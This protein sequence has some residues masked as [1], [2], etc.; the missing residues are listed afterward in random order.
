MNK[1][2]ICGEPAA[3]MA[4]GARRHD[5]KKLSRCPLALTSHCTRLPE[6]RSGTSSDCVHSCEHE[7]V[8]ERVERPRRSEASDGLPPPHTVQAGVCWRTWQPEGV[9]VP[10]GQMKREGKKEKDDLPVKG[11]SGLKVVVVPSAARIQHRNRASDEAQPRPPG[12]LNK[13]PYRYLFARPSN[14]HS[15][16]FTQN[17]LNKLPA[18]E[19][20]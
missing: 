11:N 16:Q 2:T 15:T 10:T 5:K 19:K 14:A 17:Q 9:R 13:P 3:E 18:T 4:R 12:K 1:G 7:D 20:I 8:S 6:P